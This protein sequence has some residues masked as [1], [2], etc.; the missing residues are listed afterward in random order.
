[1]KTP[2]VLFAYLLISGLLLAFIGGATLLMPT[3]MKQNAGIDLMGNV[4]ILNDIR[5]S[6]AL[7]FTLA[8]VILSG[9]WSSKFRNTATLLAF[10]TFLSIGIGRLLSIFI[11]G[12]PVDGLVK[13]TG[14]EFILGIL[15]LILYNTYKNR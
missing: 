8:I 13:A 4:S 6:S 15:G 2:K 9:L 10:L 7:L 1:M 14:L 5:A 12:S 11:D 3:T